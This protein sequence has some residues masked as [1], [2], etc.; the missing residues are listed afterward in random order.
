[1]RGV[2]SDPLDGVAVA[3]GSSPHAR[4]LLAATIESEH[5]PRII[6]AC[7]GFTSMTSDTAFRILDHPRMR[8]V[9]RFRADG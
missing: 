9:Y 4:G 7:A 1:M 5:F 6:P 8:G 3:D 2:Y